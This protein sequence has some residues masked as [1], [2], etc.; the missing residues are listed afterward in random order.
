LVVWLFVFSLLGSRRAVSDFLIESKVK[1]NGE[2]FA[3]CPLRLL[4]LFCLLGPLMMMKDDDDDGL[5]SGDW[6]RWWSRSSGR[7]FIINFPQSNQEKAETGPNE[8]RSESFFLPE[9]TVRYRLE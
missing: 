4:Q 7:P 9:V 2:K 1:T 3:F 5:C 8:W 6:Q